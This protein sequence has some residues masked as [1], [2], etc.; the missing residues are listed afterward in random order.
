L[1]R[2]EEN[3]GAASIKLTTEELQ[4]MEDASAQV[5]NNRYALIQKR[6]IKS[7]GFNR[8]KRMSRMKNIKS[9]FVKAAISQ[10]NVIDIL[11]KNEGHIKAYFVFV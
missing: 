3:N 1:H 2:L 5:K 9:F 10:N 11:V 7:T 8:S 6:W 4:E